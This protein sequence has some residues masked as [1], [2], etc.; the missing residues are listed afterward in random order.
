[1]LSARIGD[2]PDLALKRLILERTEGNPLFIEEL[3]EALFDEGVLV[4]NGAV[5]VT[6]PLGQ[7]KIPPTVQG[8]L[9]ARIDRLPAEA[10]ELLQTLAVIGSE[11]PLTVAVRLCSFRA[12]DLI[13]CSTFSRRASLYTSSRRWVTSDIPSSTH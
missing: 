12:T 2:S 7:L 11:F 1:M 13:S 4:R 9:A 8:I 5:K 3:V 10:K 6:R